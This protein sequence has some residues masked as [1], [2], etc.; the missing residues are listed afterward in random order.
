MNVSVVI[1]AYQPGNALPELVRALV[2]RGFER[3]VVVDDGSNA[4]SMKAFKDAEAAGAQIV[5]HA[6]NLGKGAALRTGLNQAAC[7][8]PDAP[9][10]VTADADGQHHPEDVEAVARRL[11]REPNALVLG[12][13][14]FTGNVPARSRIGNA[15]TRWIVRLLIGQSL[16]DT[17]TGLRGIPLPLVAKLLR[18]PSYGYEFELDML[19]TAR[20]NGF[21]VAQE[22]IRTV[23]EDGNKS[24]HFNPLF[25]SLRI[26]W[27]LFRFTLLAMAT[28]LI[29]NVVFWLAWTSTGNIP[30]AQVAGRTAGVAF[31]YETARRAV[32]LSDERH[33]KLMP[34]YLLLVA[35]NGF[36][37]YS[38]I[39][40]LT[41]WAGIGVLKA[42]LMAE[43][44][45][46]LANFVLQRDLV[47]TRRRE[48]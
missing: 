22:P 30:A 11:Q 38:M 35:A 2:A 21:P 15:I 32:F 5:R 14:G 45:L 34:K 8:W 28:A 13:R 9:G 47:F 25:D 40:G 4:A 44:L 19:I 42:K 10:A 17:Q 37:S 29:D 23:Y 7:T 48:A 26:Y 46:F 43:G 3:I 27:V 20:H 33:S 16:T 24:S 39:A 18:V 31:N 1:P 6:V 36:V 41:E 12:V